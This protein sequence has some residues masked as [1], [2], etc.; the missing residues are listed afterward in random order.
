MC[1]QGC[2]IIAPIGI[3]LPMQE[4]NARLCRNIQMDKTEDVQVE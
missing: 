3:Q 2:L 4:C 1:D